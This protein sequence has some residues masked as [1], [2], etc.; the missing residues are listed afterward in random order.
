MHL[1]F[2]KHEVSASQASSL[3]ITVG[4]SYIT[5]LPKSIFLMEVLLLLYCPYKNIY[6]GIQ[7]FVS[8]RLRLWTYT[9]ATMKHQFSWHDTMSPPARAGN[10]HL[11]RMHLVGAP[12][13]PTS[14]R[15]KQCSMYIPASMSSSFRPS[16]GIISWYNKGKINQWFRCYAISK[17]F[18]ELFNH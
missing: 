18:F 17:H 7:Y 12:S 1:S 9:L 16:T 6:M 2:V 10:D 3:Q 11:M 4:L 8:Y 15:G 5:G 13:A 14:L